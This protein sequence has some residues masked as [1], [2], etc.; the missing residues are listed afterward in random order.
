MQ[1]STRNPDKGVTY[2]W[3]YF[4]NVIFGEVHMKTNNTIMA[5]ILYKCNQGLLQDKLNK[6]L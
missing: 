3:G 2:Q 4:K 6:K 1:L 5:L